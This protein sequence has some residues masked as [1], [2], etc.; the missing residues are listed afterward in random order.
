MPEPLDLSAALSRDL[1]QARRGK[2]SIALLEHLAATVARAVDPPPPPG[3]LADW[4]GQAASGVAARARDKAGGPGELAAWQ[5]FHAAVLDRWPMWDPAHPW[6]WDVIA[7]A[8]QHTDEPALTRALAAPGLPAAELSTRALAHQPVPGRAPARPTSPPPRP[9]L[10]WLLGADRDAGVEIAGEAEC[11]TRM[12]RKLLAAGVDPN[13]PCAPGAARPLALARRGELL[14]TLLAFGARLDGQGEDEWFGPDIPL[15]QARQ[16]IGAWSQGLDAGGKA[17]Q[18]LADDLSGRL[19]RLTR[20]LGSCLARPSRSPE[21]LGLA[22]DF[23]ALA[24]RLGVDP[25][26]PATGISLVGEWARGVLLNPDAGPR[27]VSS[28]AHPL[29]ALP[30]EMVGPEPFAGT[31][32]DGVGPAAWAFLARLAGANRK[33][34]P[35][36]ARYGVDSPAGWDRVHAAIREMDRQAPHYPH[37]PMS[38]HVL[39]RLGDVM[40]AAG[41]AATWRRW[42]H[43]AVSAALAEQQAAPR[44]NLPRPWMIDRTPTRFHAATRWRSLV[45]ALVADWQA[46]PEEHPATAPADLLCAMAMGGWTDLSLVAPVVQAL[47][48]GDG[49]RVR[50]FLDTP[51]A[52]LSAQGADAPQLRA[53]EMALALPP[54]APSTARARF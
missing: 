2:A 34:L 14:R 21:R 26:R 29:V 20:Q 25:L 23:R 13:R 43:A 54:P 38:W 15:E 37:A 9:A 39:A 52:R 51:L 24:R 3:R 22:R 1:P 8:V 41:Q 7:R 30:P 11:R 18:A 4:E 6:G 44:A 36:P 47:P 5:A 40:A 12:L 53:L 17:A 28:L 19:P 42:A 33:D 50:A 10:G 48:S 31:T 49:P 16:Q 46:H 32:L 35:D 45:R 27:S